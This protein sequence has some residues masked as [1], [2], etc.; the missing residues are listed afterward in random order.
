MKLIE[1]GDHH[2]QAVLDELHKIV[3]KRGLKVRAVDGKGKHVPFMAPHA[4][5]VQFV[6]VGYRYKG[7]VLVRLAAHNAGTPFTDDLT[8]RVMAEILAKARGHA[9]KGDLDA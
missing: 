1:G 3:T 7:E 6:G 5:G 2:D 4:I 8:E 9:M